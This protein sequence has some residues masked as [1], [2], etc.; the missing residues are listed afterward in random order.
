MT[1][2]YPAGATGGDNREAEG[3]TAALGLARCLSLA[4]A[5]TFA[6][7]ALLT[8]GAPSDMICSAG[9]GFPLGGMAP[10]YVLMSAFHLAPWLK[11][12]SSRRRPGN[13]Q[14]PVR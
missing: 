1:R 3:G 7:M 2:S 4:A 12:V 9:Q 13:H 14:Y 10:M 8:L 11:L 5:P 6:T